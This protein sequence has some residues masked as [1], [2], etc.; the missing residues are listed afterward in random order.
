VTV[1]VSDFFRVGRRADPLRV[2]VRYQGA[3][4]FDDPER[5]VP[6]LY[7]SSSLRTCL[8]EFMLPWAPAFE[9]SAILGNIPQPTSDDEAIDADRDRRIAAE[10]RRV[11]P[12]L[13]ERVA[14][15]I[16]AEPALALID[17]REVA[18]RERLANV[19]AIAQEMRAR[20]F[21]QLDRGALLSPHRPLTQAITGAVVRGTLFPRV[22]GLFVESRHAGD[23]VVVFAGEPFAPRLD[24]V[25]G[26]PLTPS[27]REVITTASE[28]GLVP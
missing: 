22:D 28:L 17:L 24:I 11:P 2:D 9:A 21:A 4:R 10:P 5:L 7:G 18:V 19:E 6:M 23:V 1:G 14:V 25:A 20:G 13:Y 26:E 16:R 27:S 15:H 12:S 3:G 8:L